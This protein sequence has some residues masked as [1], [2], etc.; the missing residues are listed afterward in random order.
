M[1]VKKFCTNLI[2][3]VTLTI[4]FLGSSM[5]ALAAKKAIIYIPLDNRPVCDEYPKSV[6]KAAGY[7]VYSPPEQLIATRTTPAPATP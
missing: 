4:T 7:K 2:L 3:T 5:T 6:L 1:V